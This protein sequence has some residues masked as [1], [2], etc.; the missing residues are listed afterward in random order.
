[1][2]AG[3]VVAKPPLTGHFQGLA[4][5]PD[6]GAGLPDAPG[7]GIAAVP[8][9]TTHPRELLPLGFYSIRGMGKGAWPP[10]PNLPLGV[11]TS[12]WTGAARSNSSE[13]AMPGLSIRNMSGAIPGARLGE[14]LV[15]ARGW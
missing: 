6:G 7:H 8:V 1:M 13:N 12:L 14:S 3:A 15:A 2:P 4:C 11:G 5:K 9:L 10:C